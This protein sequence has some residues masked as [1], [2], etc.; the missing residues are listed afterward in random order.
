V[1]SA[2][3]KVGERLSVI[4]PLRVPD[5]HAFERKT[6]IGVQATVQASEGDGTGA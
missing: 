4:L 3:L 6:C 2:A 5:F 1:E